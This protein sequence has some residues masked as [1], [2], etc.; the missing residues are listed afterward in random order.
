[1]SDRITVHSEGTTAVAGL[2][3]SEQIVREAWLSGGAERNWIA[4]EKLSQVPGSGTPLIALQ[5]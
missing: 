2:P 4:G 1:M 5:N 3:P